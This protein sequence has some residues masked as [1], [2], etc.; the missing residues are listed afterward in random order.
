MMA[1]SAEAR[2]VLAALD[3]ELAAT[4]E[5]I[6][7]KLVWTA[8]EQAVLGLISST[9]DRKAWLSRAY[10]RTQDVKMRVR[11]SAEIR[12]LEASLA[13]LLKQVM[14]DLPAPPTMRTIRARRAANARW[15]REGGGDA[16]SGVER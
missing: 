7:Q 9:I 14:P 3:A 2:K 15:K 11:L 5:R 10:S 16:A 8:P 12:L 4:S 13:R 6:G 1:R